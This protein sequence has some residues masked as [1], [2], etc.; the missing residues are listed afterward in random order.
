M[1]NLV[2]FVLFVFSPSLTTATVAGVTPLFLFDPTRLDGLLENSEEQVQV[3]CNRSLKQFDSVTLK[4]VSADPDIATVSSEKVISCQCEPLSTS[5][6]SQ[7]VIR[8]HFLGRTVINVET[9]NAT[10]PV[11]SVNGLPS[12]VVNA[13]LPVVDYH[14][15]VVRKQ[16]FIDHLFLGLVS[17]MVICANVGMGCKIDLAVVK[18]V[19]TKPIAPTIGFCCQYLIMPLVSM[20]LMFFL[21][22]FVIQKPYCSLSKYKIFATVSPL[23]NGKHHYQSGPH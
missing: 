4:V 2:I 14:V 3:S 10:Q 20:L 1:K 16:R 21:L 9:L 12:T 17:F 23:C 5:N 15:S 7:F 13:S 6:I 11:K 22:C 8:G 19:L 18:E